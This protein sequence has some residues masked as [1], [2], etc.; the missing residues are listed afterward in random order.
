MLN[1]I[2]S[3]TGE[4][5][6]IYHDGVLTKTQDTKGHTTL[7]SG[8]G[9]VLVGRYDCVYAVYAGVDIDELLFFN[10]KL[11]DQEIMDITNMTFSMEYIGQ[12]CECM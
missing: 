11:S 6:S 1:Y 8:D 2:G 7:P 9:R 4:G 12:Q 5:F 3:N 10:E